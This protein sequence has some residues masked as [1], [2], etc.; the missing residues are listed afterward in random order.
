MDAAIAS[1]IYQPSVITSLLAGI[2]AFAIAAAAGAMAIPKIAASFI[3]KPK[4]TRLGDHIKFKHMHADGRIVVCE[5]GMYAIVLQCLGT[6]LKFNERARQ[7]QLNNARQVWLEQ[8]NEMGIRVREF[9][10]RDRLPKASDFS[11]NISVMDKVS[12][13]WNAGLPQALSTEFFL[14]LTIKDEKNGVQ[15]LNEAVSQTKSILIDYRC[16]ELIDHAIVPQS[17]RDDDGEAYRLS[18]RLTP[19]AFFGRMLSPITRPSPIGGN[20]NVPLSYKLSTDNVRFDEDL[21]MFEFSSG[22]IRKYAAVLVIEEW[23]TP[24][25]ETHMLDLLSYPIEMT[26]CH[27]IAPIAKGPALA[28]L[29]WQERM[30][31][32]LQPGSDAVEQYGTVA[33]ALERGSEEEQELAA[34]QTSIV[35]YGDTPEEIEKSYRQILQIKILGI[36]PVWPK[37]TMV[38]HWFSLFPGFDVMGRPQR[39][40]SGEVAILSTFQATPAGSIR[41]DWGEGP[42]AMFETLDGSPYSFQWHVGDGSPP[43]GHCVSIGPSGSGKTTLI[44]FLAAMSL[45]HPLVKAYFFDRGRGCE[46]IT[47][48]LNGSYL[49]FDGD[50]DSVSLNPMQLDDNALNRQFLREWMEL[51]ANVGAEDYAM[52]KEIADA[53]EINFDRNLDIQNRNL[54]KLYGSAFPAGSELRQR[55][56]AW[57]N[58]SQYGSIVC[59]RRDSLDISTRL[60]GFDFTNVLTD[61]RLGPAMVSYIMHRILA[62]AKGDPRLIFIDETEPLLRN[63]NFRLR[64]KKLLQEGRKERQV[65][66]SCFQ[67]PQAPEEVGVGDTIRGQC[68]TVFFFRNLQAEE[69][70]YSDWRLTPRELDFVLGRTYRKNKYA[71]LVKRYSDNPESIILNTDLSAL[72]PWMKIFHSGR[73]QVLLAERLQKEH[74]S[75]FLQHYLNVA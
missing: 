17:L 61:E 25:Y 68:P 4:H 40:L 18:E 41:S 38:Q 3:P 46:V 7:Q 52:Q 72:G 19:A 14:V 63:E 39:L 16:D 27:D 11:H 74:G 50:G 5:D 48:A 32:G 71:V 43:L 2:P 37:H 66:I 65:I 47:R 36:T 34:V 21:S 51:I 35:I 9:F 13:T 15:R 73:Q 29:R 44:T 1:Y 31:P 75:D 30:A 45:R 69:K 53:I 49:F 22:P 57:T 10:V 64:F 67:R 54:Q 59:A 70:D 12:K 62:E 23:S 42:I 56:L 20:Y 58:P 24:Q 6:D 60:A 28:T 33:M 55:L 26:I 8:M